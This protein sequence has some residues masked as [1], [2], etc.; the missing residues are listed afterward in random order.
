MTEAVVLVLSLLAVGYALRKLARFPDNAAD[1]LNRFVVD[2]C[3]PATLLRVLPTLHFSWDLALLALTPWL[4][5][6][7]S[8]LLSRVLGRLLRLDEKTRTALFLCTA[9]GNTSFLGYPLC[10]AL[11]G[12]RAL[13]LAAVYDQLGSFLIV[14]VVAPI[15]VARASGGDKPSAVATLKRVVTFPPFVAL[16]VGL[17]PWSRPP[18]VEQLLSQL[19]GALVPIAIVA[20]GLR[21]RVTPPRE[22]AAFVVGLALKLLLFPLLA[23]GLARLLDPPR[24]VAE[25]LVLESAMPAMITAGALAMAAGLAPELVAALVGWGVVAALFTVPMWAAFLR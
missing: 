21:L 12:P 10:S 9:L 1:V 6:A 16:V 17:L 2:L 8:F 14:S 15:V 11:L 23:W 22:L 19:A 25:V 3:V 24:A 7:L 4:L 18:V 13:P 5:A 20:V